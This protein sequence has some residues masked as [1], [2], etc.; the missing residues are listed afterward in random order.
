MEI[1]NCP[2]CGSSDITL[3]R[4]YNYKIKNYFV[5]AECE[6]CGAKS[7]SFTSYDAPEDSEWDNVACC[8]AINAWNRRSGDSD[9]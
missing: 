4:N 8:K 5:W 3:Y 1:R 2:F 9:A 6:C 7:K